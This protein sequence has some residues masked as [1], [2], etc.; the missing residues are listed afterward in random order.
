M[1]DRAAALPGADEC[2]RP[3]GLSARASVAAVVPSVPL[4]AVLVAVVLAT[5]ILL[6][7]YGLTLAPDL[8]WAHDAQDGGELI[9]AAVT[10]GVPHPPG[11]PIYVLIG[12]LFSRL[13]VGT[14]AFRFN[15]LSAVSMALAGGLLA[16]WLRL[17]GTNSAAVLLMAVAGAITFGLLPPVWSQ[18]TVAEVYGLNLLFVA[19]FL[20]CLLGLRAPLVAG[21]FLGLAIASHLS[22][23]LLLPLALWATPRP[24]Y[25]RLFIGLVTGLLPLLLVALFART[26]SPVVWGDPR[27]VQGWWWLISG[28]LYS[29]NLHPPLTVADLSQSV[30]RTGVWWGLLIILAGITLPR[31][32]N[33]HSAQPEPFLGALGLTAVF[34]GLFILLYQTPDAYVLTLPGLFI[35][36]YLLFAGLRRSWW[37]V[38]LLPVFLLMGGFTRQNLSADQTVRPLAEAALA[39]AP[40]D[41]VL[42]TPGD[43]TIFTLWYFQHVEGQRPDVTLVDENLL[44]FDWYR[45]RLRTQYPAL[46]GLATDDLTTLLAQNASSPRCFVGLVP[47]P[48][49]P[50]RPGYTY[51]L[52]GAAQAP[53]L[54]CQEASS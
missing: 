53:Y 47:A 35:V 37:P 48:D 19:A 20:I 2:E 31:L 8:T 32:A 10:L 39:A 42:L 4:A 40:K 7:I 1:S 45:A 9:T 18:A 22:S 41:A 28:Q 16:A 12:K 5:G 3:V 36:V 27:T 51:R 43:R 30:T 23:V 15:L 29:A 54:T 6:V 44:G 11:Y 25:V 14:V 26:G 50:A 34:Y 17:R 52:G 13:P 38:A 49:E 33:R 24:R 21:L 46:R